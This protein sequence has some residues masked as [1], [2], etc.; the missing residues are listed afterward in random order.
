MFNVLPDILK[1]DIRAE[2]K[3]RLI[4]VAFSLIIFLQIFFLISTIPVWSISYYKE[5]DLN[6]QIKVEN[7][8]VSSQNASAISQI[9]NST[10][11]K[12]EVI[13]NV[14]QYP[15][16]VP[17]YNSI[18]SQK[19]RGVSINNFQYMSIASSSANITI[20]GVS[21]TREDLVSFV[22]KLEGLQLFSGVDS[23]VSNLAKQKNIDFVI[24]LTFGK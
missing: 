18:I 16:V 2:Y 3:L 8:S 19:I 15:E 24:N 20:S 12:I 5:K 7:E 21:N 13:E 17:I 1:D 10:N 22:K 23:P 9:I 14:M 11:Q 6:N 4:I